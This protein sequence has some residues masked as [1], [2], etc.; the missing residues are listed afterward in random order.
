MVLHHFGDSTLSDVK[1]VEKECVAAGAKTVVVAGDIAKPET[2]TEVSHSRSS[3]CQ[4]CHIAAS[5]LPRSVR[6]SSS[7]VILF[8]KPPD[9]SASRHTPITVNLNLH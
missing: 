1:D 3:L 7:H 5:L 4:Q 2:A 9:Q 8:N 6:S